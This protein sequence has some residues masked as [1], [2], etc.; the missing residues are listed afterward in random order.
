M[1]MQME[2]TVH[3]CELDRHLQMQLRWG[4]GSCKGQRAKMMSFRCNLMSDPW[5]ED[6]HQVQLLIV[7]IRKTQLRDEL[8]A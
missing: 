8:L 5:T 4:E 7:Y 6:G 2:G 3:V 1:A